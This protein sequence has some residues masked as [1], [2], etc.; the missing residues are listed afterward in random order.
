MNKSQEWSNASSSFA[1]RRENPATAASAPSTSPVRGMNLVPCSRYR[2][3]RTPCMTP[4]VIEL[5]DAS[6][7][8]FFNGQDR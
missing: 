8:S 3:G 1:A 4:R 5:G 2:D 7:R 6:D